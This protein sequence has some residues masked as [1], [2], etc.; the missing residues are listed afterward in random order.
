MFESS[1]LDCEDLMRNLSV[2]V[3]ILSP[4]TRGTDEITKRK[5]YER[6]GVQEYWVVDPTERGDVLTT[7][8]LPG[9]A[10]PL[11]DVFVSPV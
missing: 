11:G 3:E 4:S 6:F 9:W 8:L 5:L 10:A 2:L 1:C 7:P